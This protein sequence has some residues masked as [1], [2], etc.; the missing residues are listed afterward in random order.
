MKIGTANQLNRSRIRF[1]R[2][3]CHEGYGGLDKES[4]LSCVMTV[5][6]RLIKRSKT[7]TTSI[8]QAKILTLLLLS[9]TIK[10]KQV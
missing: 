8:N 10:I 2:H 4:D 5:L 1:I 3:N 7:A 6:L 9:S